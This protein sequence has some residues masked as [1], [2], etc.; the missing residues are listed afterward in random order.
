[1]KKKTLVFDKPV[2]LGASILNLSKTLMYDF[3]YSYIKP[4]YREKAKLLFTDTDSLAYEIETKNFYKD[5][6]DDVVAKFAARVFLCFSRNLSTQS[7]DYN[8]I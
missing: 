7:L 2:Y 1:M 3:H 4:K 5:I 6:S 8:R